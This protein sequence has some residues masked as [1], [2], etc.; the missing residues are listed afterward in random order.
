MA[1]KDEVGEIAHKYALKNA[2][3][4]GKANQQNVLGKVIPLAKGIEV[5]AVMEIV[6]EQVSIVN[7]M[8]KAEIDGEY[9]KFEKEFEKKAKETAERTTMPKLAIE[10]AEKGKVV[11]RISPGP[12]GYMHIGHVKQALLSEQVAKIYDGKFYRYFDDTDPEKCKQEYVDAMMEDHKWLGMKFDKTYYASDH[13]ETM[14]EYAG[15]LINGKKAY[16]CMCPRDV[17]KEKRFDGEECEH[18]RQT[19]KENAQLFGEMLKGGVHEGDATVRFV[20]NMKAQNTTMR[21]PVILRIVD[22]PH[23]RVGTRYRV[24]PTYEFNTPIVDSLNGITDIIRSKEYELRNEESRAILEALG[25]RIP[26]MHLEARLNIKGN[27]TQ[28][29]DIRKLID[30]KRLQG[31]DDPRLLTIMALRRRGITPQAIRNFV[32]KLGMTK[33]DSVVPIEMLLAENKK[34]IDPIAKHLYFVPDPVKLVVR[35]MQ[36]SKTKLKLHPTNDSGLREYD[37][38]E[39]F[40][41]SRDDVAEAEDGAG[42]RLKDFAGV[43]LL[44]K[45]KTIGAEKTD[46]KEGK[47]VQ[48]VSEGNCADCVVLIPLPILDEEGKFSPDSL[49]KVSG[50]VESYAERLKDHEIVQ[51]ERFGYCILDDKKSMQFIFISK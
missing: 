38:K 1:D 5:S 22:T 42:F 50:F 4:F 9:K 26:R 45:G 43:K 28:K 7:R 46:G 49:R 25:L 2:F 16:T 13:V 44:K 47:I 37:T 3:D 24:W 12:S 48:W 10:G 17:M 20:G 32:L 36:P 27:I 21:D 39:T 11:T 29:R 31:W 8:G 35:G 6:E 23:Y 15:L 14:Y 30:E 34:V 41:I 19:P 51:F 33:T 18:R 40:Y